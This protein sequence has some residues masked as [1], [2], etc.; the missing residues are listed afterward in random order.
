M[1][2][3]LTTNGVVQLLFNTKYQE[4]CLSMTFMWMAH[5]KV[6][7]TNIHIVYSCV[8]GSSEQGMPSCISVLVPMAV[9]LNWKQLL[10]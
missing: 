3:S 9:P 1:E 6:H 7:L 10:F 2:E 4:V 5:I 8:A